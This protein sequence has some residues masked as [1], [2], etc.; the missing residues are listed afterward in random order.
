MDLAPKDLH[1]RRLGRRNRRNVSLVYREQEELEVVQAEYGQDSR[2]LGHLA[3]TDLLRQQKITL[4]KLMSAEM[5][6]ERN[7]H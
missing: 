7:R 3:R 6:N 2:V 4:R 1:R 5:T